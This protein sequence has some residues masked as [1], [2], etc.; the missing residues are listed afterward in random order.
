MIRKRHAGTRLLIVGDGPI[1]EELRAVAAEAGV[2]SCVIFTGGVAYED[3]PRY[4][5]ASD[6]CAAPFI[7]E[8]D[9]KGGLCSLKMYEYLACGRPCVISRLSGID[10]MDAYHCLIAVEPENTTEL[11]EAI[12]TLLQNDELR[13][14]MGENGRKYVVENQSWEKVS[15]RVADVLDEVNCLHQMKKMCRSSHEYRTEQKSG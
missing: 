4:I 12:T 3:V 1:L 6:V 11:A 14:Q 5:N 8:V 9:K 7:R 10:T 13:R 2:S 15:E